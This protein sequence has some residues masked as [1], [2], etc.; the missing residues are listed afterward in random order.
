[1]KNKLIASF[2]AFENQI[3]TETDTDFHKIRSRAMQAFE[4]KGFPT[5][6][7]ENWKYTSLKKILKNDYTLFPDL[8]KNE[9]ELKEVSN[10]F[11]KGIDSYKIVFVDGVYNPYLSETTHDGFDVCL[12]SSAIKKTKYQIVLNHYF[13]TIVSDKDSFSQLNTAFASEGAFI[14]IYKNKIVEKPIQIVY[15]TTDTGKDCML[16]PRNLIIVDENSQVKIVERHQSL[17]AKKVFT[18]AVTEIFAN[19]RAH[20][21]YYKIQNDEEDASLIDS[22]YVQQK[23]QS[24]VTMHTYSFGGALTRN[25][26]FFYQK[27]PH[28]NTIL[29][30]ITL[31]DKE[32]HVDNQTN[33]YHQS[34]DC[35]SHE[36]YKGIY[37]DKATGVFNGKVIVDQIAQKTDAFQQNDSILLSD[38]SAINSKPQLE[39]FA[40]DVACSHGCTIGQLDSNALFYMRQRGIP[41]KEAKALL[42]FAFTNELVDRIRIPALK[43]LIT[44]I[45]SQKLGVELGMDL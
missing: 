22:T 9:L 12:L 2:L 15:F 42:L 38:E 14:H 5:K 19:Q 8:P 6:K 45:V 7:D 11:L 44:N 10:Y 40:D 21:D 35:E 1:M 30:G 27:G 16:Q 28:C 36:L 29:N 23:K 34:P 13:N 3:S 37:D 18:N 20:I 4:K 33:V 31:I 25:N 32:Q 26:L 43:E 17:S 39:I 24:Q 41:K